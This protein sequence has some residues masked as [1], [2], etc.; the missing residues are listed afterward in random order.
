MLVDSHGLGAPLPRNDFKE[1]S[2]LWLRR[3][4][5]MSTTEAREELLKFVGVGRKVADC[6]LLM[7]LDKVLSDIRSYI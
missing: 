1:A 6:I 4:R 2:E 5:D 3:L 7:S